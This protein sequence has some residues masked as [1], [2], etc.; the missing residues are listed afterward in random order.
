MNANIFIKYCIYCEYIIL[1]NILSLYN[2]YIPITPTGK[3][4]ETKHSYELY[5]LYCFTHRDNDLVFTLE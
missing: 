1:R 5:I 2:L 4:N 3:K